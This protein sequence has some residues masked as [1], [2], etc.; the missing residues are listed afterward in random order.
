MKAQQL[1][2]NLASTMQLPGLPL[3]EDHCARLVFDSNIA[4]DFECDPLSGELFVHCDL[5][6]LPLSGREGLYRRLLEANLYG[7]QTMRATLALDPSSETVVLWRVVLAEELSL[8]AFQ[9]VVEDFLNC[10][11]GWMG[12]IERSGARSEPQSGGMPD[13][14]MGGYMA[15]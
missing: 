10:A 9:K 8:E 2:D 15:V 12:E 7:Q 6:F 4:V 14:S 13:A 1:L 11:E 5:G 3:N